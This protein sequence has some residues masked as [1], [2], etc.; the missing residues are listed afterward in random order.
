MFPRV[1][2]VG[3][4]AVVAEVMTTMAPIG[5]VAGLTMTERE[6]GIPA[7]RIQTEATEVVAEIAP[8]TRKDP[9]I[10][11][12]QVGVPVAA[13]PVAD[14]RGVVPLVVREGQDRGA[15]A[16]EPESLTDQPASGQPDAMSQSRRAA[17]PNKAT[18]LI[19]LMKL[20]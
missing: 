7:I 15:I 5:A 19:H 16:M 1:A 13:L 12:A 2:P 3:T 10:Q 6:V 8:I 4:R 18:R 11:I 17:N 20:R 9:V 14:R